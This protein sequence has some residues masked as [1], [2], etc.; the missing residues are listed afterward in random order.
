MRLKNANLPNIPRIMLCI[1]DD[2]VLTVIEEYIH[3]LTLD[4]LME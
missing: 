4:Q 1:C 3:G 2:S